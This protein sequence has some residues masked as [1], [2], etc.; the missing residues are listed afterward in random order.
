M[1]KVRFQAWVWKISDCDHLTTC[2]AT[3]REEAKTMWS[4]YTKKVNK[5]DEQVTTAQKD[6]ANSVLVFVS[7]RI[8]VVVSIALTFFKDRSILRSRRR[9]CRRKL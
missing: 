6:D 8:M 5:Y 2:W 7:H 4:I 9:F 3:D 1:L